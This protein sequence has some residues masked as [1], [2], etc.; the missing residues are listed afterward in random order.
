MGLSIG[1]VAVLVGRIVKQL[2][3]KSYSFRTLSWFL[4]LNNKIKEVHKKKF[5]LIFLNT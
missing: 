3:K 5:L 2:N 1:V 4:K